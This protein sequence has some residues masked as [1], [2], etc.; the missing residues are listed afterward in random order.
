M[1][2]AVAGSVAKHIVCRSGWDEM[3]ECF[4]TDLREAENQLAALFAK[5]GKP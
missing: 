4:Q 5:E 2:L 3:D 1:L